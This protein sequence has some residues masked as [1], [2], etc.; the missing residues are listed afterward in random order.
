[1]LP[2]SCRGGGTTSPD[3]TVPEKYFSGWN[4][5]PTSIVFLVCIFLR[6]I[7]SLYLIRLGIS[8]KNCYW[9]CHPWNSG[10]RSELRAKNVSLG[11]EWVNPQN[12]RL[13]NISPNSLITYIYIYTVPACGILCVYTYDILYTIIYTVYFHEHCCIELPSATSPPSPKS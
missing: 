4:H 2:S 8:N 7:Y 5:Q 13:P 1:M 10:K 6:S 12:G 3:P 9:E 11:E